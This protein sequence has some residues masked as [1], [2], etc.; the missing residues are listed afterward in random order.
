MAT[1]TERAFQIWPLLVFAAKNQ[2]ILT[3]ETVGLCT[4]M[5]SGGLG[6]CLEPIQSYCLLNNYPPLTMLVVKKHEGLP[7]TGF[8]AINIQTPEDFA[9]KMQD[10]FLFDWKEKAPSIEA[11]TEAVRT[12]P[13]NGPSSN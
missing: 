5:F 12:L 3:Y 6:G 8:S 13:S 1:Q 10:I 2:Q 7:G 11:L 4:G 9:K